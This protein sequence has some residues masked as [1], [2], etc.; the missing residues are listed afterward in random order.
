MFDINDLRFSTESQLWSFVMLRQ[1]FVSAVM[2]AEFAERR[3]IVRIPM[4]RLIGLCLVVCDAVRVSSCPWSLRCQTVVRCAPSTVRHTRCQWPTSA[5]Y[6]SAGLPDTVRCAAY[7]T[8]RYVDCT[9]FNYW[10]SA[11]GRLCQMFTFQ[12]Q[13][14]NATPNC[15]YFSVLAQVSLICVIWNRHFSFVILGLPVN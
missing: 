13:N 15:Q 12:C 3:K 10:N 4:L 9:A 2:W 11:A 6:H 7:C 5:R 1:R 14:F 8:A